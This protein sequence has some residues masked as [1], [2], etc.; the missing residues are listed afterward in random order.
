MLRK[1]CNLT[2]TKSALSG[3]TKKKHF[4][5]RRYTAPSSISL[6]HFSNIFRFI[7]LYLN[8]VSFK[9]IAGEQLTEESTSTRYTLGCTQGALPW[10]TKTE[11]LRTRI[12][13]SKICTNITVFFHFYTIYFI[14]PF[15]FINFFKTVEELLHLRRLHPKS[16]SSIS[17]EKSLMIPEERSYQTQYFPK[18]FL[19]H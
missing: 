17:Q 5:S 2:Y 13:K 15:L 11:T 16:I 6:T 14:L 3:C 4:K 12:V 7:V 10:C 18:S 9:R 8:L 19:A 1:R